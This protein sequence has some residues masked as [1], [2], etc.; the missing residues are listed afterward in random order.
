MDDTL[1]A[2]KIAMNIWN[3]LRLR[4]TLIILLIYIYICL[5]GLIYNYALFSRFDIDILLFYGTSDF[6]LSGLRLSILFAVFAAAII[7]TFPLAYLTHRLNKK[8]VDKIELLINKINQ[9]EVWRMRLV[10]RVIRIISTPIILEN[11]AGF[12]GMII[13]YNVYFII[14]I[15]ISSAGIAIN[16]YNK[17]IHGSA[18][19]LN[20]SFKIDDTA[21]NIYDVYSIGATQNN[22]FVFNRYSSTT[23]MIP[24]GNILKI[25]FE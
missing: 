3:F 25:E 13:I 14:A 23:T 11:K 22:L 8:T 16:K 21:Q 10:S 12:S 19:K 20:I 24:I 2:K 7:I 15:V 17:I 4:P 5:C 9:E 1:T 6:L 18:P